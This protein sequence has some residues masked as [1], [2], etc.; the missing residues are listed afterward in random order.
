M[1]D[2]YEN[3]EPLG[4]PEVEIFGRQTEQRLAICHTHV[5]PRSRNSIATVA[6]NALSFILVTR[7]PIDEADGGAHDE[8][9]DDRALWAEKNRADDSHQSVRRREFKMQVQVALALRT[10]SYLFMPPSTTP[11]TPS[12][13]SHLAKRFTFTKERHLAPG[14]RP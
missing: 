12:A 9:H 10:V 14:E 1:P 4:G 11:S 8:H 7:K 3:A 2:R 5:M 13:T 6:T